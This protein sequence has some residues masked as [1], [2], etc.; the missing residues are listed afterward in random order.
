MI[1]AGLLVGTGNYTSILT[2][3]KLGV[4][5]GF[6]LTQ[7]GLIVNTLWGV[8]LFKEVATKKGLFLIALS[9]AIAIAGILILNTARP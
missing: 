1:L 6:P 9:I 2:I 5:Q 7:M 4:A 8:F 3:E